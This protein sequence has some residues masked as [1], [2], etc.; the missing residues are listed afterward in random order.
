MIPSLNS[1]TE[2]NCIDCGILRFRNLRLL[3]LNL[4]CSLAVHYFM[5]WVFSRSHQIYY[6]LYDRSIGRSTNARSSRYVLYLK[7][8]QRHLLLRLKQWQALWNRIGGCNHPSV[9]LTCAYW[10]SSVACWRQK[11]LSDDIEKGAQILELEFR[12]LFLQFNWIL[13][14]NSFK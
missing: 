1:I 9:F 14:N 12:I 6:Q 5:R 4:T 10:V 3:N 11:Y 2:Y 7:E 13:M 8:R